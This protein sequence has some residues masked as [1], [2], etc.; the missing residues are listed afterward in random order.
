MRKSS[1]LGIC[2]WVGV[3]PANGQWRGGFMSIREEAFGW[4]QIVLKVGVGGQGISL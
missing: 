2:L 1:V 4:V 3:G